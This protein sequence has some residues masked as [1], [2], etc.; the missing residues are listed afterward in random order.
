MWSGPPPTWGW[1][2]G[3]RWR[4]AARTASPAPGGRVS[5]GAPGKRGHWAEGYPTGLRVEASSPSV[6]KRRPTVAR[7]GKERSQQRSHEDHADGRER[8]RGPNAPVD[9]GGRHLEDR[10]VDEDDPK[11]PQV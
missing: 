3:G 8:N 5:H 4:K 11:D 7:R 10:G 2:K 1:P 6:K 9:P